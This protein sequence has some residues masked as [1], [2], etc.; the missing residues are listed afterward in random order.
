MH[1]WALCAVLTVAAAVTAWA[2][3]GAAGS[4][5]PKNA[6]SPYL[7]IWGGDK[8]H[9]EPDFLAV[10]DADPSSRT[11][12]HLIRRLPMK[13]SGMMPHHTE[14]EF[15]ASGHVFANGWAVGHTFVIDAH[16]AASPKVM[17]DFVQ[18]GGYRFPHSFVRLPNGHV[19]ATFQSHQAGYMPPGGLVE[20]DETGTVIRSA[21]A[22][23]AEVADEETWPYSMAVVPE[24]DRVVVSFTPMGMPD[25]RKPPEGSWPGERVDAIRTKHI[26]IWRLSDL[27]LLHTLA[28]PASGEGDQNIYPAEPRLLSDGSV[29]VNTFRC[30]LYRVTEL[31]STTPKVQFVRAF[32]SAEGMEGMCAVP[33]IVGKYWIQTVGALPGLIALDISDPAKPVEVSQLKLDHAF[34]MPHWLA[35]DRN[36]N[37]LVLTGDDQSWALI[38]NIDPKTGKLSVDDRF[39]DAGASTPGVRL[40]A[41]DGSKGPAALHGALF[42]PK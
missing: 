29:Y 11:Y 27:K 18:A 25:W 30:G 16:Q 24:Q 13:E 38:V 6:K 31:A 15:P 22:A 35:A 32:P 8:Q 41:A 12:G 17:A 42:A 9:G 7:L 28:L 14:Y 4:T 20:L 3:S 2:G 26:Q 23:T 1:R 10:I 34:H 5:R 37:R 40:T 21:S 39:R 36:G 33:V 19:L